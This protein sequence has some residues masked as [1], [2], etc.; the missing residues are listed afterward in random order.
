M[1]EKIYNNTIL[2]LHFV[3]HKHVEFKLYLRQSPNTST[4]IF[5]FSTQT[6][7]LCLRWQIEGVCYA[8]YTALKTSQLCSFRYTP[9][10]QGE[11]ED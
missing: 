9:L 10:I 1:S 4:Y 7:D 3:I 5:N 2:F 11:K 8:R 6:H